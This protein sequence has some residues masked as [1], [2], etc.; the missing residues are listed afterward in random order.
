MPSRSPFGRFLWLGFGALVLVIALVWIRRGLQKEGGSGSAAEKRGK[1]ADPAL[2]PVA[3]SVAMLEV[4]D[5]PIWLEGLGTVAA[6]QQALVRPQV[7]G[8]LDKV[9]FHEGQ[10]VKRGDLIA[11][12]DPRPYDVQLHTA[13]GAL[14]RDKATLLD[15]NLN[16]Q[17]NITLKQTNL[18]AQQ[19][20]DDQRALVGQAE[21]A[22]KIDE[23]S[24]ESAKL[25]LDYARIRAPIDGVVGLRL[26]DIGNL[27]HSADTTGIVTIT[28]IDPI[29]V[30]LTLPQNDL[31]SILA[32][33]KLGEVKIEIFGRD[34]EKKLADGALMAI[35]NTVNTAT[36]TIRLKARITNTSRVLW[37]NE[38]VKARV[39]V[40]TERGVQVVPAAAIQ[41]GPT[42]N[43]V[44]AVSKEG[45][46]EV[47]DVEVRSVTADS[48]I[49]KC[50]LPV[51]TQIVIEGQS[52]LRAGAKVSLPKADG[53]SRRSEGG[54]K[55]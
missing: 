50:D 36:S 52:Q 43:F 14:L 35:D 41:H 8:K 21:G 26:T 19:A 39:L 45:T 29:A 33:Q 20:V 28:Q 10:D 12:I 15:A 37:P 48:A 22:V 53:G 2:R 4:R 6:W 25:N 24:V 16:L 23:A 31:G 38:F 32:A 46:A 5:V 34:R 51:G 30:F 18:V 54:K 42:N 40:A 47:V 9:F 11:Q 7:D 3:V 55:K 27:I 49:V 1:N 44:Y 13:E 17:R